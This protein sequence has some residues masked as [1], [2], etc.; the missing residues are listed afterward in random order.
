MKKSINEDNRDERR[1]DDVKLFGNNI[2]DPTAPLS[3]LSFK[4]GSLLMDFP[5]SIRHPAIYGSLFMPNELL[6]EMHVSNGTNTN[7]VR[8]AS[9]FFL[10]QD[11]LDQQLAAGMRFALATNLSFVDS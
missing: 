5:D 3:V 6:D 10:T 8:F 4:A 2:T 1:N 7:D 11:T 9:L